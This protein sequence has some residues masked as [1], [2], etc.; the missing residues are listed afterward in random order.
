VERRLIDPDAKPC[1]ARE[2]S[3]EMAR[4]EFQIV[5]TTEIASLRVTELRAARVGPSP[6]W[7]EDKGCLGWFFVPKGQE[8]SAQGFNPGHKCRQARGSNRNG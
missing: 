3:A 5:P 4:L 2:F 7:H 8:D 1:A 6:E